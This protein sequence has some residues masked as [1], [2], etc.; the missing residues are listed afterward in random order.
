MLEGHTDVVTEGDRARWSFD[1]YGAALVPIRLGGQRLYG[2]GSADMKAGVAAAIAAVAALQRAAPDL[3]GRVR[4]GIVVDEEGMMQGIKHFIAAGWA[5]E[6]DGAIVCEP[7]ELELCLHQKGAMRLHV[8]VRGVMAHGAMPY[9]GVNPIVG[10]MRF[11]AAVDALQAEE[12]A[13]LGPH[14]FLGLPWLT[15]TILRAPVTGE[16]QLN[17]MPDTAYAALDVRTVPGQDHDA[18]YGRLRARPTA[19]PPRPPASASTSTGSR[20]APGPR[21]RPTTRSCGPSRTRTRRCWGRPRATAAS[22][23][24]PTAPSCTRPACRSSRRPGDR[25][26]PHQ[27]DEFVRIDDV[28]RAARLYAAAAVRYLGATPPTG[29]VRARRSAA[30]AARARPP[31]APPGGPHDAPAPL[32]PSPSSPPLLIG[33]LALAQDP[34]PVRG[35]SIVV[36]ISADPPGWDPTLSTS[37]E[38]A[39]VTYGNVF[40]G[41]VRFDRHGE[42]VPALATDWSVSDDGLRWTFTLRAGRRLP[43]R[44]PAHRR[45]RDRQVR[46][47]PR[48]RQR[49]RQPGLL[50]RRR[51]RHGARPGHGRVRAD[52]PEPQPALQPG[53]ARRDRLP[54]RPRRHP[55]EPPVG[56]GPFRFARYVEG[57]RSGWSASTATGTPS[58]P[59]STPPRSASSATPTPASRPSWRATST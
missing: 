9:A 56:T 7:E 15:P 50:R 30:D 8:R 45:R 3:P 41:L 40:E 58:S 27:V 10:L 12:Q 5:D 18:L 29:G 4:L 28:V 59:T 37:Q 21:R 2:R 33:G 34:P 51:R 35:G 49:P 48:P 44:Q 16:A 13:R 6:V 23:A 47:R 1:P 55:A 26:I 38:I 17:V 54:G 19:S 25:T 14:P 42:I 36:A 31:R 22:P 46:A 20:A 24:P 57:A 39:R 53:A 11:L 43:R 32:D 52:P